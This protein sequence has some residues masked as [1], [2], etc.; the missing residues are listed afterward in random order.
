MP[1]IQW[2]ENVCVRPAHY[3]EIH[4]TNF[5]ST[6]TILI[7]L[8]QSKLAKQKIAINCYCLRSQR[9]QLSL[10]KAT[11]LLLLTLKHGETRQQLCAKNRT[12]C[13]NT[14]ILVH[15]SLFSRQKPLLLS[16]TTA[17]FSK[18]RVSGTHQRDR[19][20]SAF[21]EIRTHKTRSAR[22]GVV[23]RK[24]KFLLSLRHPCFS[25]FLTIFSSHPSL[26]AKSRHDIELEWERDVIDYLA[27]GYDV[28]YGARSIKH[29]VRRE[30]KSQP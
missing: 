24:G 6:L 2:I 19:L 27:D 12:S 15:F 5:F 26:Q 21:F 17:P 1:Q 25:L 16:L 3:P 30:F 13:Y 29:E 18:G 9:K 7:N 10:E 4:K 11:E 22:A 20:L 8:A 23:A 14:S 28:H